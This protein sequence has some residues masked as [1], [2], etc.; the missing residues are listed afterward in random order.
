MLCC[1][2]L[3]ILHDRFY[4]SIPAD[5]TILT[6]HFLYGFTEGFV[7]VKEKFPYCLLMWQPVVAYVADI[8]DKTIEQCMIIEE[9]WKVASVSVGVS[10]KAG[11]K[12]H[13]YP[14]RSTEGTGIRS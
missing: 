12:G 3:E 14:S 9:G 10:G 6:L 4:G 13:I 1:Q 8:W 11:G 2:P 5:E 7:L